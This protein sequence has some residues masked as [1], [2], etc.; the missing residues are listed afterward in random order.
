M[1]FLVWNPAWT[2]GVDLIDT[3][4]RTLLFSID[5]LLVAI[6]EKRQGQQIVELLEFLADFVGTHLDTEETYMRATGYPGLAAHQAIHEQMRDRFD[7]ILASH[8]SGIRCVDE[9]VIK[10]LVSWLDQHIDIE[11]RRMAGHIMK[12]TLAGQL[13]GRELAASTLEAPANATLA[14]KGSDHPQAI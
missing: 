8:R 7:E 14:W 2:T 1:T 10:F 4:H 3:Q 12:C 11:D 9:D 13:E 6:H 5:N